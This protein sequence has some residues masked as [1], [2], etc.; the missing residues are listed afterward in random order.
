[1]GEVGAQT[2]EATGP[3]CYNCPST[4]WGPRRLSL[5]GQHTAPLQPPLPTPNTSSG[6]GSGPHTP[7]GLILYLHV[8]SLP[9]GPCTHLSISGDNQWRPTPAPY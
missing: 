7:H 5:Q 8:L 9:C 3:P 1:M 6:L 2:A 4:G